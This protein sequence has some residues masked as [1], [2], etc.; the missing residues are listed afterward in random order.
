MFKKE[1][2]CLVAGLPDLFFNENKIGID[3]ISFR[4]QLETDLSL[5]DYEL[6]KLI[7]LT[8][9][10]ENLLNLFLDR[11]KPFNPSGNFSEHFLKQQL[12]QSDVP[13][14]L[15]EY[16]IQFINWMKETESK[17]LNLDAEIVIQ[18]LYFEYILQTKNEFLRNWFVFQLHL[19]NILTAIN[20]LKYGYNA[21]EQLI[22]NKENMHVWS[23]LISQKI[24]PELFKDEVPYYKE[25]FKI[26]ETE[27]NW[28]DKEKA[29]D[30]LKWDYLDE[31]T[32]F[33]YFTIEKVLSFVL[34]LNMTERWLKLDKKTGA[35]LLNKLISEFKTTCESAL[36]FNQTK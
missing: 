15:P 4:Q 16:M 3:T 14:E 36:E 7:Y 19:K 11:N 33:Y 2:H 5:A 35:A 12:S 10:N 26:A 17:A 23:Y 9:D 13:P 34:K 27:S 30:K 24:K 8:Y 32:F 28:I 1:Y 6:V 21:E 25:I 29:L 31:N 22:Q 18:Q 20:C